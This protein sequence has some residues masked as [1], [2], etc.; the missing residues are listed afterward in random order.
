MLV[1][2]T[3]FDSMRPTLIKWRK[4]MKKITVILPMLALAFILPVSVCL[5]STN[6]EAKTAVTLGSIVKLD[7]D[8]TD[9]SE[10]EKVCPEGK[11]L[12]PKTNRCKNLQ[13]IDETSTGKT[14]TTYD[15]ETGEGTTVKICNDGYY[16][17]TE[18]NRC[19]K[20]KDSETSTSSIMKT[21]KTCPE[22]KE[23][24][25][26]TNRCRSV[27]KNDGADYEITVP[28]LGNTKNFIAMGSIIAVV[29]I[30]I[31]FIVF[32][33]RKEIL[34]FLKRLAPHKKP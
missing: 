13:E 15:P 14:I 2:K 1:S 34:K 29:L 6:V 30:G 32:Q 21:E 5:K 22:G 28:E 26:E 8:S 24:N 25:P 33:F 12:N 9:S 19:N 7:D 4:T 17:N 23:L 27:K 10:D 31:A 3:F 16:L 20:T 18:T 11:F